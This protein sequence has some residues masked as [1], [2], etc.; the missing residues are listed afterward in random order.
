MPS[1]AQNTMQVK[2]NI[3]NRIEILELADHALQEY[4]G[5]WARFVASGSHEAFLAAM[6]AKQD[7]EALL[8]QVGGGP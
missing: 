1:I 8:A 5:T 7:R 2:P 6:A 4:R 3:N